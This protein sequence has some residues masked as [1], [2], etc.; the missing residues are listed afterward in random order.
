MSDG[1]MWLTGWL[2]AG[3]AVVGGW[4]AAGW[5]RV[6][7]QFPGP[8]CAARAGVTANPQF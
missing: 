4:A 5:R 2:T 1:L 3:E 8:D 7:A 6:A